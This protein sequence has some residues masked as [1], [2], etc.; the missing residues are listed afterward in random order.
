MIIGEYKYNLDPKKRLTL[1]AKFRKLLGKKAVITKGIDD[2]LSLYSEKEWKEL[3][4][5]LA[6][7]PISQSNARS[8]T[9]SVLA[10]AMD[11]SIDSAGRILIPEYLK[12]YAGLKKTVVVAGLYT[13]I[14]IWSEE[15]WNKY[16][17]E[18]S[19]HMGDI[20]EGLKE[21]DI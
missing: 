20:T 3:A 17:K 18:N 12:E 6:K 21:F 15:K 7:L 4:S 11:V 13:R 2:C 14:E 16:N 8:F 19:A 9:R 10:G 5:K 1:P